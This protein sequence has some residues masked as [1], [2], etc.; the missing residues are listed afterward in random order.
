MKRKYP[1]TYHVPWSPGTTSDDKMHSDISFFDGKEI[2]ITEKMDGE[3]TTMMSDVIHARSLDSADHLS[4]HWVKGLWGKIKHDIPEE[5]KICGENLYA[6][7]SLHY[8]NLSS[9]FLVFSIWDENDFCLSWDDTVTFSK[10][11]DLETVPVLWRGIYNKDFV[12]NFK[13]NTEI[14]E[15]FVIR[16]ADSFHFDDFEQ[17]I[18]KWVRKG[19]VTT[20]DHWMF[21][22]VVPNEL[23]PF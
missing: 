1:R 6:T 9:Y 13:V 15:G 22:K 7:H 23:K 2:I 21:K 12:E 14:Q 18:A 4:R 8:T 19:H 10:F 5:W 17:S 11:L 20:E 16:I 3:N